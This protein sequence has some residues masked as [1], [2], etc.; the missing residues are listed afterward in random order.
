MAAADPR[1][2]FATFRASRGVQTPESASAVE[3]EVIPESVKEPEVVERPA[4]PESAVEPEV[5]P[6]VVGGPEVDEKPAPAPESAVGPEVVGEPEVVEKPAPA[7]ESAV[8][9]EVIGEP[10]VVERPT[11]PEVREPRLFLKPLRNLLKMPVQTQRGSERPR[12]Q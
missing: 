2:V 10:E 12:G 1:E 4:A 9:P 3:P 6:E 8:E 7:P 5:A 11:P